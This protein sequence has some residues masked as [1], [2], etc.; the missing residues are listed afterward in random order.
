MRLCTI[1]LLLL[2]PLAGRSAIT[3]EPPQSGTAGVYASLH[4]GCQTLLRLGPQGNINALSDYYGKITNTEMRAAITAACGLY[5]VMRR[6]LG[7]YERYADHLRKEYPNSRFLPLLEKDS[8]LVACPHCQGAGTAMLP[9]PDCGGTGKCRACSGRGKIA[10]FSSG[11]SSLN[12]GPSLS[13]G[14][15]RRTEDISA[16]QTCGVCAGNGICKGCKGTKQVKGRCPL[17]QGA[18][19]V[20]APLSQVGYQDVLNYLRELAFAAAQTQRHQILVEGRW[21]DQKTAAGLLRQRGEEYADFARVAEEAEK[22]QDYRT[23]LQLLDNVLSRH[24]GSTYTGDVRR[25]QALLQADE[26]NKALTSKTERCTQQMNAAA[27]GAQRAIGAA[28]DAVLQAASRGTNAPVF[29]A[30]TA[31][32]LPTRPAKWHLGE[33][34]LLDRSARLPVHLECARPS[35]LLVPETWEFR[36]VFDKNQW[37]VW[38]AVGP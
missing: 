28:V 32:C 21:L 10:G 9:C 34:Q 38:Q 4:A 22:A 31:P 27:S 36:L 15:P 12:A 5:W 20:F 18:A 25:I 35:G 8:H 13:S 33:P 19:N 37:V 2:V 11:G 24:P 30:Q 16:Q 6:N 7:E 29:A 26:A 14:P 23:A 1:C 3:D 17:C